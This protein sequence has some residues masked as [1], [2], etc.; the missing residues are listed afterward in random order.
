MSERKYKTLGYGYHW[1]WAAAGDSNPYVRWVKQVLR[2]LPEQGDG[3]T[4]LDVG[5]GDGYPA[6]LL[7]AR[8]YIVTGVD[9][10]IGPLV[11][12]R[13]RVSG[14]IFLH[15]EYDAVPVEADYVLA[16]E[17]LE[18]MEDPSLLVEAVKACKVYAL[19][20]CPQP[21]HDRYALR[22]Y[23]EDEVR[24]LFEGC[25]VE[26]LV[27]DGEHRLFQVTP[28]RTE[29]EPGDDQPV[30]PPAEDEAP[31]AAPKRKKRA[32]RRTE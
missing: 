24:A 9:V 10:L 18:H 17:S 29:R 28:L 30:E 13:E 16:F 26:V 31:K 4:L 8:G 14:A 5:C 32:N 11:V 25:A 12:A 27:N 20:S 22:S 1:A 23:T 3:A 15:A 2:Y 7:V 6:S 21:G 19:I